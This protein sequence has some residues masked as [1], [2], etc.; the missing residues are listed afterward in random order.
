MADVKPVAHWMAERKMTQ[1]QIVAAS[2]L[3]ERVVEAIVHGRYTPSPQQREQLAAA[4]G[5]DLAQITW[6]HATAVDHLY[7]HGAQFGRSP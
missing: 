3:E 4:L 1:D 2:G 7:G 6:D 5:V